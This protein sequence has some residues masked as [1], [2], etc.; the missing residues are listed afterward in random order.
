[1]L[2]PMLISGEAK[3]KRP[4]EIK[5]GAV[6]SSLRLFSFHQAEPLPPRCSCALASPDRL[7]PVAP[8]PLERSP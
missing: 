2:G 7:P 1:M 3:I 8:L 4:N 6:V 5:R